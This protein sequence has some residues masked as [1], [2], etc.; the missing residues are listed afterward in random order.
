M[1]R[2]VGPTATGLAQL[3][4]HFNTILGAVERGATTKDLWDAVRAASALANTDLGKVNIFD[5]N[6]MSGYAR[7]VQSAEANLA[8]ASGSD[9]ISADMWAWAPWAAGQT[10][11]WLQ[12]RYQI[13][14]QATMQG[15]DGTLA[16]IWGVTD[17]EG[18]IAG[19]TQD[20]ILQRAQLSAENSL[21]TGSPRVAAQLGMASGFSLSGIDRVQ[22]MRL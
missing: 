4:P 12:D 2:A 9:V 10:D 14:Y 3:M 22:I 21:D 16:P 19:L 1:P 15:E 5:M 18:D 13:R 6:V 20:Q 8:G 17:L 7:A 11:P